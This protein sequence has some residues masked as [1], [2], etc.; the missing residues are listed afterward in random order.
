M[1]Y[2]P[3]DVALY[4]NPS[5]SCI[6]IDSRLWSIRG[7]THR[8]RQRFFEFW[9]WTNHNS[10]LSLATNQ[11]ASLCIDIISRQC[12]FRVCFLFSFEIRKRAFFPYILIFYY[13]KQ[14]DSMLPCVC[15][16]IRSSSN[17]DDDG[18]KN[19]TNLHIWQWKTGFLHALRVNFSSFDILKT[20]S[21]FLRSEMTCF[22]VVWTTWAFDDKCSILS[23]YVPSAGSNW[24][25][26]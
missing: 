19:R 2:L 21:F 22:A 15:S 1:F 26:G 3:I 7:R 4:N 5:Y 9:I 24:I 8:W 6:L 25:Q 12:Y 13:I 16:V 18:N 17:H 10:L 20:F 11:F 14:I 23:S